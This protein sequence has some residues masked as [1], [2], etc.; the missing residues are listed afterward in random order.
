MGSPETSSSRAQ[1]TQQKALDAGLGN[2]KVSHGNGCDCVLLAAAVGAGPDAISFGYCLNVL[3][4]HWLLTCNHGE[5]LETGKDEKSS[6]KWRNLG[7]MDAVK[8]ILT[9]NG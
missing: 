9:R 4:K 3:Q 7:D 6:E 5:T 2:E 1:P 8:A